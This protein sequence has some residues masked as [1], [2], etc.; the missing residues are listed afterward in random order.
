MEQSGIKFGTDNMKN[1]V[2]HLLN[3]KD[4]LVC[5][6]CTLGL[7]CAVMLSGFHVFVLSELKGFLYEKF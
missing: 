7:T 2:K 6:S 4:L 3:H 5:G 1:Y